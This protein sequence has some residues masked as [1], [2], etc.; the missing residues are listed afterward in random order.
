MMASADL[1][2]LVRLVERAQAKGVLVGDHAQLGAVEA[3]GL[4]RLLVDIRAVELERVRRF[5]A[6]WEAEASLRLRA[7]DPAVLRVYEANG[8]I[9][10]GDRLQMADAAVAAWREARVAG[11]SV[12]ICAADHAG[13]DDLARRI[14]ALRV[15]AGEVEP[16]G[17][18]AG[19][20][21]VGVGEEVVTTRNDRRLMTSAGAWVRNG[22]RWAV[23]ARHGDGSL[24]VSHLDGRGRVVLP[25]DYV[26][27][28]VSL[29]YA[30][31]VHKAQGVTVDRAVVVA[32]EATTAEALYV[33]MTRG[34]HDNVALA[35]CDR[36][37][38]ERQSEPVA[39]VDVL[40][41]AL[42]RVSAEQA[43]LDVLRQELAA[44]ESLA[45]VA[46]RLANLDAWIARECPPDPAVQLERLA[47]QRSHAERSTR[48]GVL[49]RSG[50]DDRRLLAGL[51]ARQAELDAAGEHRAAWL[52][53]HA[54][55]LAYR[56]DLASQVDARRVAL[57]MHAVATRPTHLVELLGPVPGDA[58]D[59]T[60]AELAGRVE[61]YREEWGVRL[62]DL[63]EPPLDGA[64]LR[65]WRAVVQTAEVLSP[66][67][68]GHLDDDA[69]LG[70]SID[71]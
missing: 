64:Q 57:G 51:D 45:V 25:A 58:A 40:A 31:T 33:G 69:D 17:V 66:V 10:G 12:V 56:D 47:M 49:T 19:E 16:T 28:E 14:R 67:H 46:P 3:G 1:A 68:V 23:T 36:L 54:D 52:A 32:D 13:V 29:A 50:R 63:R 21:V 15:A 34:R 43:A 2:R 30:L 9:H 4:F 55:I 48:P 35:V 11:A 39:A 65:E 27:E 44:S 70:A 18:V 60:W 53:E 61:A 24:T 22:D 42:G 7:R 20:Q 26:G 62:E 8:R 38:D 59:A 41:A 6:A 5:S 71:L 37:D